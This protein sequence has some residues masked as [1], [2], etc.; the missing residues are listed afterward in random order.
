M[1]YVKNN[2]KIKAFLDEWENRKYVKQA[3]D[4]LKKAKI[5][6]I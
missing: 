2:D 4:G 5:I 3:F 1:D 6:V